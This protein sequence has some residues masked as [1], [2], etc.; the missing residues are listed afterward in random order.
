MISPGKLHVSA[1]KTRSKNIGAE[2]DAA[3]RISYDDGSAFAIC[4]GA[5]S[6]PE[7]RLADEESE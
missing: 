6:E 2:A 3:L 7:E 5:Q 4:A 1:W